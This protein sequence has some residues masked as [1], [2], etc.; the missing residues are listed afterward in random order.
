M[1]AVVAVLVQQLLALEELAVAVLQQSMVRQLLELLILAVVVVVHMALQPTI[2][3]AAQAL[4]SF[5]MRSKG[6]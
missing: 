1:V 3:V 6:E 2:V 4:L 5:G